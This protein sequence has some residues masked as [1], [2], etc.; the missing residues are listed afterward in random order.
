MEARY[1]QKFQEGN[2]RM[3]T[4]YFD[5][6]VRALLVFAYHIVYDHDVAEEIVQDAFTKLWFSKANISTEG[7]LKSFLY[8][9]TRHRAIDYLR[10]HTPITSIPTTELP[11]D[12]LEAD[13]NLLAQIIHA[14]TL[15]L[16]YEEVKKLSPVQQR[17]FDLTFLEGLSAE[18]ISAR[19]DMTPNAVYIAR[20]KALAL[21]RKVCQD[22]DILL[23]IGMIE[24][25]E[26]CRSKGF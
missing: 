25:I 5:K 6:H 10:S 7:H 15:Q 13:T 24:I 14:E 18:E 11:D 12:L 8:K 9:V 17:V 16:V 23:L 4:Y 2:S 1:F 20:S 22:K 3:L 26:Y 21:L 19:L